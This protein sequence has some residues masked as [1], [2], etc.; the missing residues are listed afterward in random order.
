MYTK[1]MVLCQAGELPRFVREHT[2]NTILLKKIKCMNAIQKNMDRA[3]NISPW[4][5]AGFAIMGITAG[6]AFYVLYKE[7]MPQVARRYLIM[8]IWLPVVVWVPVY[9]AIL[10]ASFSVAANPFR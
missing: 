7:P 4:W 5:Y 10:V 6:L 3:E 8:S 9:V 1:C 2:E